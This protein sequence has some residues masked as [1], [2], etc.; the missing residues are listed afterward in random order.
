[1]RHHQRVDEN[2]L[3]GARGARDQKVG[4]GSQVGDADASVQ[5]AAHGQRELAWRIHEFLR[6]DNFT[7]GDGLPPVVG[8]FDADRGFAGNTLDK[9]GLGLQRQAQVFGQ[10]D[11]A[12]VFDARLGLKLERG[13]HWAGID[14]RHTAFHIELVAFFF[15]GPRTVL[16]FVFVELLR[17]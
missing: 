13:Y 10:A 7:Q 11:D 17:A 12:A 2:T 8:D 16:Q 14:L 1:D 4:H 15:D 3:A 9:D 5:V 6:F